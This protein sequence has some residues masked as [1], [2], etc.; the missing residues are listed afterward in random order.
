[1]DPVDGGAVRRLRTSQPSRPLKR[2]DLCSAVQGTSGAPLTRNPSDDVPPPYEPQARAWS[3]GLATGV[4][5]RGVQ[6]APDALLRAEPVLRFVVPEPSCFAT[7]GDHHAADGIE[8]A[9]VG[10][11]VVA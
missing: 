10:A 8:V 3:C 11:P 4:G 7:F 5:V 9:L 6:K 2:P 1:M